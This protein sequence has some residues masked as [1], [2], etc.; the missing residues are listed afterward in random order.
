MEHR[1][2]ILLD[3][4]GRCAAL[5]WYEVLPE[6][7][8][9]E[10]LTNAMKER[11]GLVESPNALLLQLDQLSQKEGES[12]FAFS[13]RYEAFF[14]KYM[15]ASLLVVVASSPSSSMV[16]SKSSLAMEHLKMSQFVM[17]LAPSLRGNVL[18]KDPKSFQEALQIDMKKDASLQ[19]ESTLQ[20]SLTRLF[21]LLKWMSL[22]LLHCI[23]SQYYTTYG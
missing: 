7:K 17:A 23:R 12:V 11:F 8:D 2:E 1:A 18:S 9:W 20:A 13:M 5:A 3:F 10:E 22:Q 21:Q 16:D 4:L 6:E 14:N 15:H 19:I